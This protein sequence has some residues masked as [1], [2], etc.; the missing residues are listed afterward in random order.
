MR[1][2]L[3]IASIIFNYF[4]DAW[5]SRTSQSIQRTM[6]LRTDRAIPGFIY[7]LAVNPALSVPSGHGR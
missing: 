2:R 1:K 6:T 7:I 3:R 4:L 5:G